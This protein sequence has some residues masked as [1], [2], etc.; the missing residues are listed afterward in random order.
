MARHPSD[1]RTET[2]APPGAAVSIEVVL[3]PM[4]IAAL[5]RVAKAGVDVLSALGQV[6][7]SGVIDAALRHLHAARKGVSLEPV[8]LTALAMFADRGL[9]I[10]GALGEVAD[11]AAAESGLAKL[12]A[13]TPSR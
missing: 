6:T 4:E 3:A 1:R 5:L 7:R 12:R 2:L 11:E 9:A 8:Q 10:L 13:A